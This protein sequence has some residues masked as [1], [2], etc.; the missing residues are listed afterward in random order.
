MTCAI[1]G[2]VFRHG[3]DSYDQTGNIFYPD[4]RVHSEQETDHFILSLYLCCCKVMLVTCAIA[5]NVFR[6]GKDSYD[7]PG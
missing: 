1:A 3:K 7:L 5:G 4:G 6:H 2:N